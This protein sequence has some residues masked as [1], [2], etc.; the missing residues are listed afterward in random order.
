ME[1][2]DLSYWQSGEWQVIQ[3]RLDYLDEN[4]SPYN[5]SRDNLFAALDATPFEKV[6]VVILG[7]DPYPKARNATGLAFDVPKSTKL[8]PDSLIN[9]HKEVCDDMGYE[10]PKNPS[11]KAWAARGVLLWNSTPTVMEGKPGH[12][13]PVW[14]NGKPQG[15]YW[16][17]WE[18]LTEEII[19][20]LSDKK[21]GIVFMLWGR[22][23]QEFE[24]FVDT[25]KHKVIKCIHPSPLSANRGWFGS[26]PFSTCNTY[27]KQLGLDAIDWRTS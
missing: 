8:W 20:T 7:Q 16:Y 3:E 5:P 27:L 4:G 21:L 13:P 2:D 10:W 22:K 11:L 14:F 6:K 1:W 17:E 24:K 23:A 12:Q 9:I 26:R 18:P 25:K 19:K 15:S